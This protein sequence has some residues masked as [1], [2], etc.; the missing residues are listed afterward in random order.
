MLQLKKTQLTNPN[1]HEKGYTFRQ[2]NVGKST[3]KDIAN[4][5]AV[6]GTYSVGESKGV[7]TDFGVHLAQALASNNKVVIDELGT[8]EL[9]VKSGWAKDAADMKKSNVKFDINFTPAQSLKDT[10]NKAEIKVV[11]NATVEVEEENT[12]DTPV[13]PEDEDDSVVD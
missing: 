1:T 6:G 10:I 2:V 13:T 4:S 12:P 11:Q 8:F 5:I 9:S 7:L 3:E